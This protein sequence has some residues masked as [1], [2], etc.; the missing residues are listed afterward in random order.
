ML[1]ELV[2]AVDERKC[3]LGQR[4]SVPSGL[5]SFANPRSPSHFLLVNQI[6]R[7]VADNFHHVDIVTPHKA[8]ESRSYSWLKS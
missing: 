5:S 2:V 6:L 7:I 8:H 1:D 3:D 4:H